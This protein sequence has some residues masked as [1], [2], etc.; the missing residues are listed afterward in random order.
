MDSKHS[1]CFVKNL[2]S[3]KNFSQY[4]QNKLWKQTL[5]TEGK[6]LFANLPKKK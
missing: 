5:Q 2:T 4:F 3:S 6:E 1:F